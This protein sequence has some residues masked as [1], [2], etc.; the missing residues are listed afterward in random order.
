MLCSSSPTAPTTMISISAVFTIRTIF[1]LSDESA[2][3][4]ASAER[5]KNG[6]MNRAPATALN[7]ASWVASR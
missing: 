5:R 3:C 1:D 6:R 7:V 2:S 4:P